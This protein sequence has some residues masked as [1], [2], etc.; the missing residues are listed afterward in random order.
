M[1]TTIYVDGLNLYDR[2]LRESQF[3]W[4]DLSLLFTNLLNDKY[5]I[6]QTSI[7]VE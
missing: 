2:C 4:L 3:K 1:R 5:E 7:L 6:N